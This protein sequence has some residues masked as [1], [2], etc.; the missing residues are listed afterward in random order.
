M[1]RMG[2][3]MAGL[4]IGATL[5]GG[6]VAYAA[7]I[8]AER[9]THTILVDGI[10]TPMT[11]YAINGNNYVMLRDIGDAVDFNVFWD[12]EKHCV[13][14]ESDKPYTCLLYTS[15]AADE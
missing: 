15:D 8:M 9:S 12:T 5:F 10:E 6:S 13:Q 4:L 11:A 7:G 14:V 2:T 3:F 1:K